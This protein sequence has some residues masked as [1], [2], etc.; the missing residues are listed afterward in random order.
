MIIYIYVY[1]YIYIH[2]CVW[3][4]IYVI[5]CMYVYIYTYMIYGVVKG[6]SSL[7]LAFQSQV[8]EVSIP[9]DFK[10]P[11]KWILPWKHV[12]KAKFWDGV[13]STRIEIEQN[14]DSIVI[15]SRAIKPTSLSTTCKS[16]STGLK[17]CTK[18]GVGIRAV[19]QGKIRSEMANQSTFLYVLIAVANRCSFRSFPN[20]C[21]PM[22]RSRIVKLVYHP[23]H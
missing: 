16:E 23:T 10:C 14:D 9:F 11:R 22:W 2:I 3:Y 5:W 13:L 20:S 17:S 21:Y 6:L 8:A 15:V 18:S 4:Y 19:K 12:L 1:I 7:W